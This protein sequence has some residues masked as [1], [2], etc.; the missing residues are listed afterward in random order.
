MTFELRGHEVEFFQENGY[1]V[2]EKLVDRDE[3]S[4]MRAA[5]DR[6]FEQRAGREVGDHFDLAGTDDEGVEAKLPQILNPS[7]YAP[8]LLDG[9]FRAR[10]LNIAKT[11]L[12]D[13]AEIGGDHA[14]L[15]PAR[16]GT[17]TPWH[18]D[19]AYWD[20]AFNYNSFSAWIPLQDATVENG[21]MW[22]IPGSHTMQV[23]PHHSIGHDPRIHGLEVEGIDVRAAVACPIPAGAA[24]F[25]L[26]RTLHYTGPN[27]SDA[28]RRA[29]IVGAG[30][31]AEPRGDGRRFPWNESKQTARTRRSE[32]QQ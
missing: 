11:L 17:A 9:R 2:V 21:C 14:I 32:S 6:I 12:G 31:K 8:E 1:L 25:H 23:L 19:E 20:P 10:I 13:S 4:W 28:P 15:K 3:I 24:T 5:Y 26:S 29:Y 30:T 7:R 18:Q 22:F 27:Q 16:I